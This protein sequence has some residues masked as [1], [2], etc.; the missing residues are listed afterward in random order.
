MF[1]II[2]AISDFILVNMTAIIVIVIAI[3]ATIVI[4]NLGGILEDRRN[5]K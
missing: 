4:I 3:A 5:K 1:E 2:K